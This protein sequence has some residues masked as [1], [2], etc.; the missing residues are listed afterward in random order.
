MLLTEKYLPREAK[1]IIGQDKEVSKLK[2]NILNNRHSLIYGANG[3]GK[4]SSVYAIAN[5]L[6]YE[7]IELN[8]S[9][10]RTKDDINSILGNSMKQKSLFKIKKVILIDEI[11]WITGEDRGGVQAVNELLDENNFPIVI[12]GNNIF[13]SKFNSIRRKCNLIE[14]KNLDTEFL[15]KILENICKKE[16]LKYRKEILMKIVHMDNGDVRAAINDLQS[17]IFN[18]EVLYLELYDREKK[19]DIFNILR[20]IF[21][22]KNERILYRIFDRIDMKFDELFLW[23]DENLPYEYYGKDLKNAYYY[24]SL[25]DIFNKRIRSKQYYRFL[26]YIS[27][28]LGSGIANIKENNNINIV[29]YKRGNRLLKIWINNRKGISKTEM[30]GKLN[31]ELHMS[32][33]KL[34]KELNFMRFLSY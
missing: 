21:K 19:Q 34:L 11:D 9:D 15:F 16:N 13:D 14:Y 10:F 27:L 7:I 24:L 8:A 18:K 29:K 4:T 12:T 28:F 31:N 17:L 30:I 20:I 26:V 23:I 32:K 2:L 5:E 25:A 3:V 22:T 33:K 6:N 1:D